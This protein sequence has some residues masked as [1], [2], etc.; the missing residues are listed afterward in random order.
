[1]APSSQDRFSTKRLVWIGI[2]VLTVVFL[3]A[4]ALW[5]QPS[6]RERSDAIAAACSDARRLHR[7]GLLDEARRAYLDLAALDADRRCASQRWAVD[8]DVTASSA[9]IARGSVYFAA[10]QLAP[11]RSRDRSRAVSRATNAYIQALS[12]D[13]FSTEAR[14]RLGQLVTGMDRPLT[15]AAANERCRFANRLRTARLLDEAQV[16]YAQ[17]LRTGLTTSCAR[18]DLRTVR[19]D[20]AAAHR[21]FRGGQT[22][23]AAGRLELARPRYIAAIAWDPNL[24]N[25]RA[26]LDRVEGPDPRAGTTLGHLDAIAGSVDAQMDDVGA[27]A[28]WLSDHAEAFAVAGAGLL[29]LLPIVMWVIFGLTSKPRGRKL[30]DL[31]HLPRFARPQMI[32]TGFTPADKAATSEA[33][34]AHWVAKELVKPD[35][36]VNETVSNTSVRSPTT[37]RRPRRPSSA[38]PPPCSGPRLPRDS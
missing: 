6:D 35:A 30:V 7:A 29:I 11:D 38:T 1:M 23:E 24:P 37:G 32:I 22:L 34:F 15:T 18:S 20:R 9:A 16:A 36:N 28:T 21:I 12:V 4:V 3:I 5:V 8:A 17:A 31:I 33:L 14:A 13:P 25:A 27:F 2:G 26:A 10:A 19:Q